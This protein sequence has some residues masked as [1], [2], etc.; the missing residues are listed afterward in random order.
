[1]DDIEVTDLCTARHEVS[2]L[3]GNVT[4]TLACARPQ[5]HEQQGEPLH[6]D[7]FDCV[8]WRAAT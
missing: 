4:A 8:E 2:D 5:G 3:A 7:S 6:L 1:M